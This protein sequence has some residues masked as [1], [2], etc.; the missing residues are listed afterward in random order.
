MYCVL[1][2]LM[3]C[4]ML[5]RSYGVHHAWSTLCI[6]DAYHLTDTGGS[7]VHRICGCVDVLASAI[8]HI[9]VPHHVVLLVSLNTRDP[10]YAS[11]ALDDAT[12]ACLGP[13]VQCIH[14]SPEMAILR[15]SDLGVILDPSSSY[16]SS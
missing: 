7:A 15:I 10:V 2:M 3:S 13:G 1:S 4:P 14:L 6:R 11:V 9:R 12:G 8:G 5:R 16:L